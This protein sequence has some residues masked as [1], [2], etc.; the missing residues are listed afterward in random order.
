MNP[1]DYKKEDFLT[2]LEKRMEKY[3]YTVENSPDTYS[4]AYKSGDPK[5]LPVLITQ[6]W[7]AYSKNNNPT[8]K[9][10]K[11]SWLEKF[12][13]ALKKNNK[14][15]STNIIDLKI[16]S[17]AI[18]KEKEN[19]FQIY[20]KKVDDEFEDKI[21]TLKILSEKSV[22]EIKE[23]FNKSNQEYQKEIN[24]LQNEV[25]NI[26]KEND[27]IGEYKEKID[28]LDNTHKKL[29][30]D[31]HYNEEKLNDDFDEINERLTA[32]WYVCSG[33]RKRYLKSIIKNKKG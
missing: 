32:G 29:D 8:D 5:D 30:K 4:K 10:K 2:W 17:E 12:K 24:L 1:Y 19:Q 18:L 6:E 16:E 11:I 28:L 9:T 27:L 31:N 21:N 25:K 3:G 7:Y 20:K 15:S 26:K 14:N 13:W 22:S 33:Q 23:K